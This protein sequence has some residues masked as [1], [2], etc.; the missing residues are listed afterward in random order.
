VSKTYYG[1]VSARTVLA[2]GL[3]M[4]KTRLG[5]ED[6]PLR[7]LND[8]GVQEL[9]TTKPK[10]EDHTKTPGERNQQERTTEPT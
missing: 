4:P 1:R 8:G 7:G 6:A 3:R 9:V 10:A 5:R 2:G